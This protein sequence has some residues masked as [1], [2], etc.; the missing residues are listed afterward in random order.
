MIKCPFSQGKNSLGKI[1]NYTT[2]LVPTI[3]SFILFIVLV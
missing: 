3:L 2:D 1:E